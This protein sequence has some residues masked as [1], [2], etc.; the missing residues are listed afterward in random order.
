MT[1]FP[2]SSMAYV[3]SN[4]VNNMAAVIQ[5][6]EEARCRPGQILGDVFVHS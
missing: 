4:T 1:I 3:N 6:D 2:S 5:M